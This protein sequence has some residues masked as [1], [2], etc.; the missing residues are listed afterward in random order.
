MLL[1]KIFRTKTIRVIL[2]VSCLFLLVAGMA[3]GQ[4]I[5]GG[6]AGGSSYAPYVG[7]LV[8]ESLF[9]PGAP[10]GDNNYAS[11]CVS[12]IM[13][14]GHNFNAGWNE[15]MYACENGG[16]TGSDASYAWID[17]SGAG[18]CGGDY[19]GYRYHACYT[20]KTG[21]ESQ[22]DYDCDTLPDDEDPD[23]GEPDS[24]PPANGGD[25][26]CI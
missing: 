3:W 20:F 22:N 17:P 11:V 12:W 10:S 14:C 4:C 24:I 13:D 9:P 8:P 7:D 25:P 6:R 1:E 15:P 18:A 26:G 23:P 21:D 16:C 19:D 2:V 5:P